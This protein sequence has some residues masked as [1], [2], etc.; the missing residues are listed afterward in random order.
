MCCNCGLDI[1][2]LQL[3]SFE[4]DERLSRLKQILDQQENGLEVSYRCIRCRN[5]NDCR[6]AEKVDS[7]S[8]REEAE[9]YTIKQ[10][11]SFDWE[12][13]V[14]N[15][16]LPLRGPERD[17]LSSN[18]DRAL[19]VLESQCRKYHTDAEVKEPVLDA[20]KKLMDKKYIVFLDEIPE[21]IKEKFI[22]KEV[23]YYLPW[24]IQFKPTS[25]STPV[26]P[27][28]DAS[29][30]TKKRQDGSGGRCLNDLVCKGPIDTLD[31]LRVVLGFLIG[32]VA[33]A[34]DL[35]KMYN[36]FKLVPEM[37]NLQ[38]MLFKEDLNPAAPAE[39]AI[40]TT[41]I[42]GVKSS[43]GQ[44][45]NALV[46][47]G[48]HVK[49]EKPKA[50][51][52]LKEKRYVDNLL[53][54]LRNKKEAQET[55]DETEEVLARVGI[56]TKG[57]SY[58]GED[59][60]PKETTD[61]LSIEINAMKWYTKL[62]L[63]E[64][65]VPQLHFGNSLRGRLV[66]VQFFEGKTLAEMNNFV[67]QSLTRRMIVSKRAALYDPLG[68]FEPI[69]AKLKIDE[70]AAV[71]L[72]SNWDDAVPS[73]LRH[74][75][76]KNFLLVEQLRGMKFNRAQM[77]A[78]ALDTRMRIITVVDAAKEV[79]NTAAYGGFR[80]REG[81]WSNQHLI[82][83]SV[84]GN[85][86]LPRNEL[87]ALNGGS[88]LN[89][90]ITRAL[91][92][93]VETC[94]LA[95]DSE[96]AIKWTMCDARKLNIWV[97]NRIIQIRRGTNLSN[98][99]HVRTEF[100]VA[101]IGTRPE[102]ISIA[103]VGPDSRYEQG[104]PWMRLDLE[105]AVQ[106]GIIRPALSLNEVATAEDEEDY[107]KEF[108]VEKEP[109]ILTKGHVTAAP[110]SK[111]IDKIASRAAF[112]NYGDLL[113]TRRAFPAMVRI[114]SYVLRFLD[115]IRRKVNQRKAWNMQWKGD[116]LKES[117]IRFTA[118]QVK[119]NSEEH[120]PFAAFCVF[121]I[122]NGQ[123]V[124]LEQEQYLT[125]LFQND[126][127]QDEFYLNLALTYYFR[128]ATKEFLHFNGSKQ[129]E[130]KGVIKDGILLSKGRILDGMN[131]LESADLDT[132]DL[133]SFGIKTM[134]PVI[135]RFSPLAYS[136]AMYFHWDVAKHKGAQTCSRIS[137]QHVHIDQGMS[138]FDEINEVCIRCKKK[139]GKFIQASLGPHSEKQFLVA[140]PFYA[141][142][143]DLF[144]PIRSY[145]PGFERETRASKV[146]ESKV[147][148]FVAVCIATGNINLQVCEM[149][150]TASMLEAVIRLACECGYSKYFAVDQESSILAALREI[151]VDLRDLAH[152]IY[153]ENGTILETCA[154]GGHDSHG[155]VERTI[156]SVQES[157]DDI[158]FFKM[159]L[160]AMGIQTLCKQ[161]ENSFNNLPLGFRY[162]RGPD[163]TE[164]LKMLVPNML[165]MGRINSR[166]LE[167]PVRLSSNNKKMLGKIN[168]TYEAWYKVWCDVYIPKL[169]VQKTGFKN[170]RDLQVDDLIYF[171]K[172]ES[173][174]SSP[175]TMGK[176][177]QIIRGRDGVIRRAIVKYRNSNE[178][179]DRTTDRSVRKLIKL[180][181]ADDPDLY[182][183]LSGLQARIDELEGNSD[184]EGRPLG[185]LCIGDLIIVSE[186][187]YYS[188]ELYHGEERE[189]LACGCCCQSHCSVSF[190]NLYGNKSVGTKLYE[191]R[192]I[193]LE[194]RMDV[195][196]KEN[197]EEHD[198]EAYSSKPTKK[199]LNDLIFGIGISFE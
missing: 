166:A 88:N 13:G 45:E 143:I 199:S 118:F 76:L 159:R 147:W 28:F 106:Q 164:V 186:A 133:G 111:R 126:L 72:T 81:G 116:L 184:L 172:R 124:K 36:Q 174:L 194:A 119:E 82:G 175:W 193:Q 130:R 190:H 4:A 156:R 139:R 57:V 24:R 69:K 60:Q 94:I 107:R 1:S 63:I 61:G 23:Q 83:R 85:E 31:L 68:K 158:G 10:S 183:D 122:S 176:I 163:N 168:E 30:G 198:D 110:G 178:D 64:P 35:T 44:S 177:T 144:G 103:D 5:C 2:S 80:L 121:E 137:L 65:K 8:L 196:I 52:T 96:I 134:I 123:S 162:D 127:Q 154:V 86:N 79:L 33:F 101:D 74:K 29:S 51:K 157:L 179:E 192:D 180:Y 42:Y 59:P 160:P 117:S 146:K 17:F 19:K 135:D 188:V 104:D 95:G 87:Q 49:D 12:K 138:L 47:L 136:L 120:Q 48:E 6:N 115:K 114:S 173:A 132:L 150:D 189:P 109:E 14:I 92:D 27:V 161:V 21:E 181:S 148:I 34:A 187:R 170:S 38:R 11:Y 25:A 22:H 102:K 15:C 167:G 53:D 113:P 67:P 41:A 3:E 141:C 9:L 169:M 84:L 50:S 171:Q 112:S 7:I 131:F 46:D 140:P 32:P 70:R 185:V 18:Q 89:W 73:D 16:T 75:W 58:S 145:V 142:Q 78:N 197:D 100:N 71:Q 128:Q 40:V 155:K 77:P 56:S 191:Q 153:S 98:L 54:S 66:D 195:P 108:I 26:R 152:Q 125:S 182:N 43:S 90:I 105:E 149:K 91:G 62:D 37:W 97:R 20:F 129:V 99:Y 93:W 151:K 55:A 39:E 165:R